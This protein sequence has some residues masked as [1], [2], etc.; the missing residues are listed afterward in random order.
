MRVPKLAA[1][2]AG[3]MIGTTAFVA[4][5]AAGPAGPAG[6]GPAM[7]PDEA[8]VTHD[9]NPRVP[10]GAVWTQHYF[11][12]TDGVELH[13]DVLRPAGLREDEPTPVIL[14]VGPYFAHAGQVGDDGFDVAGPSERFDDFLDGADVFA[15]GYTWVMVD[16]RGFGGSTGCLDW[17]GPGEQADVGA[18]IE[19]SAAQPWSN[20]KV[21]M[22][23]KSYDAVT[24]L[25]GN[26]LRLPEL[27]AVVAQE[28]VWDMYNYLY[29][30]G[31]PRPNAQ[32]TPQAYNGIATLDPMSDDDAR[33]RANARYEDS[34]PECL[35]DNLEN[36]Q[37]PDPASDYWAARDLAALAAGSDTPL[38]VT[39]GFVEP[40]TKPEDIQQ[41][42]DNHGGPQRGW[43][44]QW[45]HVRGNDT[46]SDGR[47]AMGREGW[48]D[49]VMRFYDEYLKDVG[50][51]VP[52][53]AYAIE[54]STGSWRTQPSWPVSDRTV[55][56]A[57][58]DGVFVD[59]GGWRGGSSPTA[60]S[61]AERDP[62][63]DVGRWDMENAPP[64]IGLTS[65]DE[66]AA[67][68]GAERGPGRG[69]KTRPASAYV[70]WSSPVDGPTRVTGTPSVGLTASAPGNVMVRLFDVAPSG[71]AVMF[72]ENVALLDGPGR[73]SFDLK[74]TDWTLG[75]GHSVAVQVGSIV[76]GGWWATPSGETVTVSDAVLELELA[77]PAGDIPT[78]G[79]ASPYLETYLRGHSITF[80]EIGGPDFDLGL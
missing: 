35:A 40:N 10:E 72:D 8:P 59:D 6:P 55:R 56:A 43:L 39:Q 62:A 45:D 52:D 69:G 16:L 23:G 11:P 17:V 24:G 77:D 42:L 73:V 70:V 13:A 21:G 1:A 53:P 64:A 7:S 30:N 37:D 58:P 19:W 76:D 12:S 33:Y 28:P 51:T 66:N 75:A 20:G 60:T 14:A 25:V 63:R 57:L 47:L 15:E 49:E 50:P 74:S 2:A 54:D 9:E 41:Y 34:H 18:A 31:V 79:A 38:F 80:D 44:G 4:P 65:A 71:D 78:A 29:S 68:L 22:Y 48:F 26:N 36:N 61:S 67:R 46:V 5:A 32:G 3:V 27:R